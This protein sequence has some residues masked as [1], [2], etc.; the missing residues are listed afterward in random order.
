MRILQGADPDWDVEEPVREDTL[1]VVRGGRPIAVLSRHTNLT[2]MRTPSLLEQNYVAVG[3]ALAVMIAEGAFPV[4]AAPTGRRR[5]APRV[6][7]GFLRLDFDGRVTYASP[8]AVSAY[9]RLGNDRGLIGRL[10]A[11]VTTPLVRAQGTVD[12][13][14]PLVLTGRAPWRTEVDGRGTTLSMRAI[15]LMHAGERVG[16]L[17]LVRDVTEPAPARARAC[18]ART[19]RSARS[20]T[21]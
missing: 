19:R 11:E 20:T 17:L 1:P 18:S 5:G 16:A 15:P 6:G 7:D 21:G 14:L 2:N 4:T 9:H 10:L 3:D 12:E 13:G 8:N